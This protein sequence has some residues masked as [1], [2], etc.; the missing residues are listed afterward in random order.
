[1]SPRLL[2]LGGNST[3]D[4]AETLSFEESDKGRDLCDVPIDPSAI[5]SRECRWALE[6]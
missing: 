5:S 1:V 2:G 6:E 3:G 4:E